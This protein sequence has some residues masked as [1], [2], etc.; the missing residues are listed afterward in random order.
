ML[1]ELSRWQTLGA[2]LERDRDAAHF[3]KLDNFG[4]RIMLRY[5]YCQSS[6]LQIGQPFQD[7]RDRIQ[8][9]TLGSAEGKFI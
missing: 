6:L 4:L 7:L 5:P 9:I 1:L 2:K 3:T 8:F